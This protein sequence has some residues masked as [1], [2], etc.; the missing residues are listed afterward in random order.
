MISNLE[1]LLNYLAVKR[2]SALLG[3]I[4]SKH[5]GDISCLNS[6][7]SLATETNFNRIKEYVKL[8][9]FVIL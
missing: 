7:H 9:I 4:T 6:F 8:K 1:K 5:H 3:E 2:V